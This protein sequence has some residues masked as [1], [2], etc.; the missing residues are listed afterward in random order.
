[1]SN[2]FDFHLHSTASD[3]SET[4]PELLES[5][6][7]ANIQFFSLTD[8]DTMVGTFEMEKIVPDSIH[9][10]RGIE[11]SCKTPYHKCHILGYDFDPEHPA[12]SHALDALIQLRRKK[13][14]YRVSFLEER[15]GIVLNEKEADWL[16]SQSSP[17]KPHFGKI[18]VERGLAPDI[19]S[20]IET[21][22]KPCK[23]E[24]DRIDAQIA[25]QAILESGGIPVWAHP[26]GGEG[27]KHLTEEE[28][29]QQLETLIADGIRGLECFYSRYTQDEIAF[30]VDQ[31]QKHNLLISGGS[32]YHGKMK[33]NL[34]IGKLNAEDVDVDKDALTL[35]NYLSK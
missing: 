7:E 26:L 30:L 33:S 3:G 22:I 17:G 12:M 9:F 11:F 5:I 14:Y 18:I 20:A 24:N 31:A 4:V 27:E 2:H 6:K 13:L 16:F 28:F 23:D 25:V 10:I 34:H 32:D 19:H 21:Y 8:H 15:F 1:M 29:H 35:Y